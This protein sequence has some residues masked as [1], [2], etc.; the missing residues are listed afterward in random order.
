MPEK[1]GKREK[2]PEL[3]P[4][5]IVSFHFFNHILS[6]QVC[7]CSELPS[8]SRRLL[9]PHEHAANATNA[10]FPQHAANGTHPLLL[11]VPQ[12]AEQHA[13]LYANAFLGSK[14]Y[15]VSGSK[16]KLIL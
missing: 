14:D 9:A 4:N 7:S 6:N 8:W 1:C 13:L 15:I 10:V 3:V 16:E 5:F 2:N 11:E 12:P